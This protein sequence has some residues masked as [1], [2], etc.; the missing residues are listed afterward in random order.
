VNDAGDAGRRNDME[1][2]NAL[3][4]VTEAI[5][6]VLKK[7]TQ[8]AKTERMTPDGLLAH[9]IAQIEKAAKEPPEKAERR[10]H[11]LGRTVEAAKQA[12]VDAASETIEVEVFEEETTA[13]ADET[14]KEISPVAAEAALGS[15][16]FAENAEDLNKALARLA[17]DLEALR[18]GKP[19]A[20]GADVKKADDVAWPFDLNSREFRD[21][22]RKA[23]DA[24]A[25]GYD[26]EP[27]AGA[28][29]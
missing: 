10:L 13:A 24:P 17:K 6:R 19:P 11:A 9:A 23:E 16:A 1:A 28:K 15:S 2:M 14:E 4:K 7:A 18:G 12:Y 26:D 8:V 22:V 5:D 3:D 27:A 29:G 25:W 21:G 20:P